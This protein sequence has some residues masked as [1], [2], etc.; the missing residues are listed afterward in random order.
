M[1][2]DTQR[3]TST[4]LHLC[5][6]VL[7]YLLR[8][9]SDDPRFSGPYS[10][11]EFVGTSV[12]G[13]ACFATLLLMQS[14]V[15]MWV[16]THLRSEAA[17]GVTHVAAAWCGVKKTVG[18]DL[19]LQTKALVAA[20]DLL[21]AVVSSALAFVPLH[22]ERAHALFIVAMLLMASWNGY[23]YVLHMRRREAKDRKAA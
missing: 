15:V 21:Y 11:E 9:Y 23:T 18:S 12:I 4:W 5:P 16:H 19:D 3:L 1:L 20:L 14:T 6:N 8:F 22:S 17:T 2:D 10:R 7:M 13:L